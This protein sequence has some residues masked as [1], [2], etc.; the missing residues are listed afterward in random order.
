MEIILAV[1]SFLGPVFKY[2]IEWLFNRGKVS[3]V[4]KANLENAYKIIVDKRERDAKRIKKLE[5]R[6]DQEHRKMDEILAGK[7]KYAWQKD[8]VEPKK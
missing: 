6:L 3:D 2:L 7:R 4:A 5:D 1:L 8:K